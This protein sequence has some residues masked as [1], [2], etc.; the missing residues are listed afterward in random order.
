[1]T[2]SDVIELR[3]ME[4][5]VPATRIVACSASSGP[6]SNAISAAL[7]AAFRKIEAFQS[8]NHISASGPPRVV[9][10]EWSPTGVKFTAAVPIGEMPPPDVLDTADVAIK[11][12]PEARALRFEHRGPYRDVRHTYNRIEEWL[13]AR[14]GIKTAADWAR[15]A[16]MWEEYLND[17]GTTPESELITRIYLTLQ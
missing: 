16:P 5:E 4:V 9:Y 12:M 15:Y 1:M 3:S 6:D 8:A 14:G 13:R 2:T 17:P 10:T 7:G 11:A